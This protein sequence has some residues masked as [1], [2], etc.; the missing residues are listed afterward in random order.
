M[1]RLT[2][3]VTENLRLIATN[4]HIRFEDNNVSR[5]DQMLNFGIIFNQLNY[6]MTN[7][8]FQRVFINIDDKK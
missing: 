4:V 7:S 2:K 1:K 6:S 3:I 5:R 8:N